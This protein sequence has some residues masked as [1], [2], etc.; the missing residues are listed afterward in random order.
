MCLGTPF[1]LED[2]RI[3]MT[4]GWN[5]FCHLPAGGKRFE[6]SMEPL[7]NHVL[8][9]CLIPKTEGFVV[10]PATTE[11]ASSILINVRK[12]QQRTGT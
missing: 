10:H 8:S 6:H 11:R 2:S 1:L 3:M 7:T 9:R 12:R 5:V 4:L